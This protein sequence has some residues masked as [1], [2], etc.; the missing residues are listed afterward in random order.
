MAAIM[1]SP[2][3][4]AGNAVVVKLRVFSL[5]R[6]R[7]STELD[8]IARVVRFVH[9]ESARVYGTVYR[10]SCQSVCGPHIPAPSAVPQCDHEGRN[11]PRSAS[12]LRSV[13]ACSVGC[14]F[15]APSTGHALMSTAGKR[16][17]PDIGR[18]RSRACAA[19]RARRSRHSRD[20]DPGRG[21]APLR[22]AEAQAPLRTRHMTR[23]VVS[24]TQCR[25]FISI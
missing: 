4:W 19:R 20:G 6:Y 23:E 9:E 5:A 8:A 12:V 18:R 24:D 21:V 11:N 2:D 22:W 16:R 10:C 1:C 7:Y 17:R 15:P 14:I 3:W 25:P 13:L